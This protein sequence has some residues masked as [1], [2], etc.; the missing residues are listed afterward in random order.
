M[1]RPR[2]RRDDPARGLRRDRADA[3]ASLIAGPDPAGGRRTR[4]VVR[5]SGLRPAS[6]PPACRAS[7]R[8]CSW[9]WCSPVAELGRQDQRAGDTEANVRRRRDT[10]RTAPPIRLHDANGRTVT[11]AAQRGRY[12]LVTFLYTHCPDVCPLIAQNL[13]A[14]VKSFGSAASGI[15]VL[16]VS[17]DP[18]GDTPAAVRSFTRRM[19]ARAA[20]SKNRSARGPSYVAP[21]VPGMPQRAADG[22]GGRP[23]RLHRSDRPHGKERVLYGAD[24]HAREVVHDLRVLMH[25]RLG[26]DGSL[27]RAVERARGSPFRERASKGPGQKPK[28]RRPTGRRA[29]TFRARPQRQPT[30]AKRPHDAEQALQ[31]SLPQ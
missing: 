3:P 4:R 14:A 6:V 31:Q 12:A 18:K 26:N 23:H 24:V 17:V 9:L 21:G 1:V 10:P 8:S 22:E 15:R 19:R 20:V 7:F 29:R 13:N 5:G 25:N 16:A 28:P 2:R 11:L 27:V 30:P